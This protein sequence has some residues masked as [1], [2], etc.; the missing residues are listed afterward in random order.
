MFCDVHILSAGKNIISNCFVCKKL[1][2]NFYDSLLIFIYLELITNFICLIE[3]IWKGVHLN[4][5]ELIESR[6]AF[7]NYWN[8]K[9]F[10]LLVHNVGNLYSALS[11]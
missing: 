9:L 3:I 4:N 7:V 6:R 2:V 5:L 11:D 10:N 8:N 1:S